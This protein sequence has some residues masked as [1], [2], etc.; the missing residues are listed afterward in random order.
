MWLSLAISL[1]LSALRAAVKNPKKAA[2]LES[3]MREVY[4]AI[5]AAYPEF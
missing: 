3:V 1:V 5:K 2:E 4:E